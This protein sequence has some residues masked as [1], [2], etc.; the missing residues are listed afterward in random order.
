MRALDEQAGRNDPTR[1]K[2]FRSISTY[3]TGDLETSA[4]DASVIAHVQSGEIF[5]VRAAKVNYTD[6][7]SFGACDLQQF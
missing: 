3:K 1:L 6:G 4:L 2:R 5:D 7:K